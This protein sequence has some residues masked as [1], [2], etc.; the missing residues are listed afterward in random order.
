[1]WLMSLMLLVC[2]GFELM[3]LVFWVMDIFGCD[4]ELLC[5]GDVLEVRVMLCGC[6]YWVMLDCW[7]VVVVDDLLMFWVMMVFCCVID[8]VLELIELMLVVMEVLIGV[9]MLVFVVIVLLIGVVMLVL[10]LRLMLMFSR[11]LLDSVVVG[12]V[13]VVVLLVVVVWRWLML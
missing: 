5:L 10:V 11:L 6:C 9:V 2:M 12:L 7:L 13:V 1:M 3:G 4:E 8:M